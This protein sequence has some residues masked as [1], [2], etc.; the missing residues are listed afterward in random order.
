M[1]LSWINPLYLT[2]LMLLAIP[3]LI[4]LALKQHQDGLRFP[5]LMFLQRI[6]RREKR[7]FQIRDRLL[8]L[9]RCLLLLLLVLAFARPLLSGGSTILDPGRSDSVILLDRS[10][11]MRLGSQWP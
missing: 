11:S 4:H 6:P 1:G 2:G 8:L 7:R 9:L 10:W 3:V 5:S